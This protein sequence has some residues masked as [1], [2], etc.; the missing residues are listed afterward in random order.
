MLNPLLSAGMFVLTF[1]L[2]RRVTGDEATAALASMMLAGTTFFL[3]TG[4]S[5][6]SHTASAFLVV[7]AMIAMLRMAEGRAWSAALAGFLAGLAVITR[8]YTPVLCLLPL[9]I[10]LLRERPVANGSTCGRLP[11]RCRR[12]RSCWSTTT[13]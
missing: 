1:W 6:F 4:A 2:A 12:S 3:V 9:T 11:A 7:G 5:Y 8:Y 10:L 13:P